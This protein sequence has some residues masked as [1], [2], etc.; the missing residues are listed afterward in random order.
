LQGTDRGE[1]DSALEFS[2]LII[3]LCIALSL[4]LGNITKKRKDAQRDKEDTQIKE[5]ALHDEFLAIYQKEIEEES[6]FKEGAVFLLEQ[7]QDFAATVL[8]TIARGK[9]IHADI[10]LK[11]LKAAQVK[12]DKKAASS[13]GSGLTTREELVAYLSDIAYVEAYRKYLKTG[14]KA[15]LK[16]AARSIKYMGEVDLEHARL[17]VSVL[18]KPQV[19]KDS[20]I[21]LCPRCGIVE[22]GVHSSFCIV[23]ATPGFYFEE[24]GKDAPAPAPA[25]LR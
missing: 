17:A 18:E 24:I 21:W 23:C 11:N 7:G 3:V 10:C 9:K 14:K 25:L 2:L 8:L 13:Y 20:R 16:D 4:V 1:E 19:P 15:R 5:G 12:V 6:I 22:V